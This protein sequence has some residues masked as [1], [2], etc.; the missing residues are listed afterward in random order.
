MKARFVD[1]NATAER[2]LSHRLDKGWPVTTLAALSGVQEAVVLRAEMGSFNI[3]NL[4]KIV[5]A[6]GTDV[7]AVLVWTEEREVLS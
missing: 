3:V 2:L 1:M 7:D 6:L 5:R 4:G